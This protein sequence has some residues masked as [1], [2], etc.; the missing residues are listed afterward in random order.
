MQVHEPNEDLGLIC[1][2]DF[3]PA[4]IAVAP[5]CFIT[6]KG[7]DS[8]SVYTDNNLM[9]SRLLIKI[10]PDRAGMMKLLHRHG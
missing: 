8:Q 4:A 5:S 3:A 2:N 6:Y 1:M 7:P 10:I 9:T